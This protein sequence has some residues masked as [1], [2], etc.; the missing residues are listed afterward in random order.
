VLPQKQH[1]SQVT[2]SSIFKDFAFR[3]YVDTFLVGMLH[4]RWKNAMSP[5]FKVVH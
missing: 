4:A 5:F 1:L 2:D 3:H